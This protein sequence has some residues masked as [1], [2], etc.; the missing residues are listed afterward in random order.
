MSKKILQ[1][2]TKLRT[3]AFYSTTL[4]EFKDYEQNPT[5]KSRVQ[6]SHF[7]EFAIPTVLPADLSATERAGGFL[8]RGS[9]G[10]CVKKRQE[11]IASEFRIFSK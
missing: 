9:R 7:A 6:L 11:Q 4:F 5:S 10:T 3:P 1:Y 8:N 2:K